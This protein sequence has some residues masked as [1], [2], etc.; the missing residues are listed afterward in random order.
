MEN[1]ILDSFIKKYGI[2]I[3][4]TAKEMVTKEI[5]DNNSFISFSDDYFLY[6]F[7]VAFFEFCGIKTDKIPYFINRM[8][9]NTYSPS[10]QFSKI[11]KIHN[12]SIIYIKKI[13]DSGTPL[14]T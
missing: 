14:L 12:S 6:I 2:N 1:Y 7:E 4:N 3:I 5:E 13:L 11:R 10:V 8:N 9:T